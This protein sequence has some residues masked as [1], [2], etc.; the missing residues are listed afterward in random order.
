MGSILQHTSNPVSAFSIC[1]WFAS[2]PVMKPMCKACMM[3]EA[4]WYYWTDIRQEKN[5]EEQTRLKIGFSKNWICESRDGLGETC[6]LPEQN[7]KKIGLRYGASNATRSKQVFVR[8]WLTWK[9]QYQVRHR[10][11]NQSN[12]SNRNVS[13]NRITEISS[14]TT[15][16]IWASD[17]KLITA[18]FMR[19]S[20]L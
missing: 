6:F 4:Y 14:P 1:L 2:R 5:T 3:V 18:T 13:T 10:T 12:S 7:P 15:K 8:L 16:K 9:A 17:S 19:L 11:I 20:F